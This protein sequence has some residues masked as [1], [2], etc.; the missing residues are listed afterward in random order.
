MSIETSLRTYLCEISLF[1]ELVDQLTIQDSL[2][3]SGIL[4][5]LGLIRLISFLEGEFSV[6]IPLEAVSAEQFSTIAGIARYIEARDGKD[7]N[8]E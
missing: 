6:T 7:D 1:P 8:S 5:S 4:D 2:F 3:T